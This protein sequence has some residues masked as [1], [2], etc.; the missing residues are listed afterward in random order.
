MAEIGFLVTTDQ[1]IWK[2][3]IAAFEKQL[4][5][6]K[7][8]VVT[9]K[10]AAADEVRITYVDANGDDTQF[11]PIAKQFIKAGVDIIVTSG[12]AAA[13]TCRDETI[14]GKPPIPVVFASA[15]DPE[16]SKLVPVGHVTGGWNQQSSDDL[17]GERVDHLIA[18]WNKKNPKNPVSQLC[19]VY[20]Y[21]CPPSVAEANLAVTAAKAAGVATVQMAPV[22]SQAD[23][24]KLATVAADAF[25]VCSDPL[26]TKFADDL[27]TTKFAAHAFAEYCD[28]HG[29]AC[30]VGP[31]LRDMFGTAAIYA[32]LILKASDPSDFAGRLP[33]FTGAIEYRPK[34]A[35]SKPKS[36]GKS[37]K[38]KSKPAKKK[39]R[40][41]R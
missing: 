15:G 39:R 28:D 33:V 31:N 7:W 24:Q 4:K 9:T 23:I 12:T 25:Y 6:L 37:A 41:K 16:G 20:N 29:G 3:Y 8:K 22:G 30:S 10:P 1:T 26:I 27:P 2:K 34:K 36:A 32:S 17:V 11:S 38:P 40:A 5:A 18:V 19:V 13:V 35:Q 21:Q 14:G